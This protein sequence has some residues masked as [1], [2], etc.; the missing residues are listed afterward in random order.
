MRKKKNKYRVPVK[1][2]DQTFEIDTGLHVCVER[3]HMTKGSRT[4]THAAGPVSTLT[5]RVFRHGYNN[6]LSLMLEAMVRYG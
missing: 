1:T 3:K 4:M 6:V 2:I 5:I